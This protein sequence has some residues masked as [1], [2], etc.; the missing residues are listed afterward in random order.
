MCILGGLS[1]TVP[2]LRARGWAGPGGSSR[3]LSSLLSAVLVASSVTV[4]SGSFM[5]RRLE[6]RLLW[7]FCRDNSKYKTEREIVCSQH[8]ILSL[9]NIENGIH[10]CNAF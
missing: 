6:I 9:H 4:N 7:F 2:F 3:A 1:S 8:M 5:A 10:G